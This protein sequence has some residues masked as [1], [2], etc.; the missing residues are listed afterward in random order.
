MEDL[1]EIFGQDSV[2]RVVV[3]VHV[4]LDF[5]ALDDA[6][7]QVVHTGHASHWVSDLIEGIYNDLWGDL[8]EH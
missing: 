5:V 6:T 2:V 3:L 1:V 4:E 7:N 8:A